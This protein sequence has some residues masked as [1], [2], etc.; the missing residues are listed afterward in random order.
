MMLESK[1]KRMDQS[2]AAGKCVDTNNNWQ[3]KIIKG[4][5]SHGHKQL[6][7]ECL[8]F[9]NT[10]IFNFPLAYRISLFS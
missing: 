6:R 10:Q 1:W 5:H 3:H 4:S 7:I 8:L 9:I 2:W